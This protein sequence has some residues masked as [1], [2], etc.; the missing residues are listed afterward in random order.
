ML[1][2]HEVVHCCAARVHALG[3]N[4]TPAAVELAGACDQELP[5]DVQFSS[6]S[7]TFCCTPVAC[8]SAEE[9]T[10]AVAG[11]VLKNNMKS[12]YQPI[13]EHAPDIIVD[14][15]GQCIAHIGE[16]SNLIRATVGLIITMI[17]QSG[18]LDGWPE[19]LPTLLEL[20]KSPNL[21]VCEVRCSCACH[22]YP[23]TSR[24]CPSFLNPWLVG[25][26]PGWPSCNTHRWATPPW[27]ADPRLLS[28]AG[29]VLDTA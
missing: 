9:A 18:N 6:C 23:G 22:A 10:R 4:C 13:M 2:L 20:I 3:K 25:W 14:I 11:I 5:C 28:T 27:I 26:C 16:E 7:V 21:H 1:Q 19:L 24:P 29:C 15:K 17:V 12:M 8:Y